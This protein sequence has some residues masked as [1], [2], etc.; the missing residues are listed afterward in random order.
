MR[1]IPF[2]FKDATPSTEGIAHAQANAAVLPL[3]PSYDLHNHTVHCGHADTESTPLNLLIRA[4]AL[5]LSHFGISEHVMIPADVFYIDAIKDEMRSAPLSSVQPLLG[6]EMDIDATEPDGRWIVPDIE[7]DYVILSAHAMPKFDWDNGLSPE[8]QR[9][10]MA[11]RWLQWF[12]NAVRRGGCAILGHPLREPIAM[13]LIDLSD[14]ETMELAVEM[15]LPAIDQEIAFEI[16]DAFMSALRPSVHFQGYL[17]LLTRLHAQ[18]MKFSRGSDSHTVLRV[19]ACE[20]IAHVAQTIGLTPGDW[21][22]ASAIPSRS[23]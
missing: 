22:D 20:G 8:L 12:G 21:L 13:N 18:G 4:S 10:R 16:N 11:A 19:G 5:Q 14:P 23:L 3:L 7:C 2:N 6:V 15:F 1:Q 9:R 17:E